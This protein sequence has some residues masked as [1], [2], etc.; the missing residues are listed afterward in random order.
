[1]NIPNVILKISRVTY[2]Y[3]VKNKNL[4]LNTY[5]EPCQTSRIKR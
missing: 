3:K 2:V 4:K 1:M 5:S